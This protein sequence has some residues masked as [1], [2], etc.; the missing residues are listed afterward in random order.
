MYDVSGNVS[1]ETLSTVLLASKSSTINVS[2]N[3]Q[4]S[5]K[6][7]VN[8]I[9]SFKSVISDINTLKSLNL[10]KNG[11][12]EKLIESLKKIEKGYNKKFALLTKFELKLLNNTLNFYNYKFLNQNAYKII[13]QDIEDLINSL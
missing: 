1:T 12:A 3:K 2:F 8:K 10:I 11:I 5:N 6:S 4:N 7:T 9:V 13:S